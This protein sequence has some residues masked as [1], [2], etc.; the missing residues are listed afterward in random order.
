MT[1]GQV[2]YPFLASAIPHWVFATQPMG[3]A[4]SG[5]IA[6]TFT[7]PGLYGSHGYVSDIGERVILVGFDPQVMQIVPVGV[8]RVNTE[9]KQVV[10]EGNVALERLDFLGYALVEQDDQELLERVANGEISLGEMIGT[11]EAKR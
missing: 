10:S 2:A 3:I 1:F 5:K 11:L 7:M 4:V 6:L 9:N 8:G